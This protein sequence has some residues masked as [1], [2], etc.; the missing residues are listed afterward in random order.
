MD[1]A[2]SNG[3]G[4]KI[5]KPAEARIRIVLAQNSV[6]FGP[7]PI[8][9]KFCVT[10]RKCCDQKNPLKTGEPGFSYCIVFM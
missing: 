6:L 1:D 9:P 5:S 2:L 8:A 4:T 10:V 3:I 7:L